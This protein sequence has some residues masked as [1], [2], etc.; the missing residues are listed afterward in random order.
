MPTPSS[1][2]IFLGSANAIDTNRARKIAVLS[3]GEESMRTLKFLWLLSVAGAV[4]CGSSSPSSTVAP[5]PTPT[6]TP[7]PAAPVLAM[8]TDPSSSFSTADVRDVQEQIMQ[9]DTASN[10]MI[11]TISGQRFS[12]YPV[13]DGYF[14][15]GDKFFQVQF[16]TKNGE[17]HAY[18]TEAVRGTICDVEVSGGALV[19]TPTDT[20]V[21]N[22]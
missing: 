11:W 13:I 21:P 18:F 14:I 7:P 20:P 3:M 8:F 17:R 10:S 15:R 12:G 22:S 4:A 16:G 9:F 6:P 19:I 5:T 2:R 1:G